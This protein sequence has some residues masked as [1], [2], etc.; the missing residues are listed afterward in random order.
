MVGIGSKYQQIN[1]GAYDTVAAA[2]LAAVPGNISEDPY[3]DKHGSKLK[4]HRGLLSNLRPNNSRNLTPEYDYYE[5]DN[6]KKELLQNVTVPERTPQNGIIQTVNPPNENPNKLPP[7]KKQS[8]LLKTFFLVGGSA[9]GLFLLYK[10]GKYIFRYKSS[11]ILPGV[12]RTGLLAEP[13]KTDLDTFNKFY[14]HA[15]A[16][17][18]RDL[19]AIRLD[20]LQVLLPDSCRA[21]E[22]IQY[23][24]KLHKLAEIYNHKGYN[25]RIE[26]I[27][28][29]STTNSTRII[30][31]FKKDR[32]TMKKK[33]VNNIIGFQLFNIKRTRVKS[34][35]EIDVVPQ[36]RHTVNASRPVEIIGKWGR[37][38]SAFI[39]DL[40]L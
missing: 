31:E 14:T 25:A 24:E 22:K 2:P 5:R 35:P 20:N 6:L 15:T 3:A 33:S 36:V 39:R 32:S 23:F 4:D 40:L 7:A 18:H 21:A 13:K 26:F 38:I 16:N 12:P 1:F 11:H 19:D 9:A 30:S 34:R 37:N 27:M 28:A 8:S 17:V 29:E 10:T